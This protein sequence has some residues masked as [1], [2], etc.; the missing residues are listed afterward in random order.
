MNDTV[1][2]T[3][4]SKRNLRV[5]GNYIIF[6]TPYSQEILQIL[7]PKYF[8]TPSTSLHSH[9]QLLL[10]MPVSMLQNYCQSHVAFFQSLPYWTELSYF[11]NGKSDQVL[12]LTEMPSGLHTA[13]NVNSSLYF[14]MLPDLC[15]LLSWAISLATSC[16]TLNQ[17][18]VP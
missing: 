6:I 17:L 9:C 14:Q 16:F 8:L 4:P 15:F 5:I 11:I 1:S 10:S 2:H 13:L 3:T 7:F 12:P 18:Q